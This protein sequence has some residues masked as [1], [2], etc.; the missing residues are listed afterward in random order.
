MEDNDVFC[1]PYYVDDY[2]PQEQCSTHHQTSE[3]LP[4]DSVSSLII[5]FCCLGITES[6]HRYGY[7][8]NQCLKSRIKSKIIAKSFSSSRGFFFRPPKFSS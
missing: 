8:I 3:M 6:P 2:L 7:A 1:Y 5:V 4:R